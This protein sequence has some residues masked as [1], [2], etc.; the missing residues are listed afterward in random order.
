MAA[1]S[2]GLR[3]GYAGSRADQ[4]GLGVLGAGVDLDAETG[5]YYLHLFAPEQPDLN[6][7]NPEVRQ[8]VYSM[9]N[10]WLDRGVD[11]FR[12]DVICLLSKVLV[13]GDLP[14]G[15]LDS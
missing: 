14:D 1:A 7:E 12:M 2:R 11:G 6:W 8:A 9:M 15:R 4:L 5:E 3:A 10:R 13:N